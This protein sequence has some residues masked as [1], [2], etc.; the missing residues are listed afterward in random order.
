ML[1]FWRANGFNPCITNPCITNT[2]PNDATNW[3]P[4]ASRAR[5]SPK[6]SH[7]RRMFEA[8]RLPRLS[9]AA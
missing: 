8:G 7:Q 4:D 2:Y 6:P 3:L 5:P 1:F 9:R